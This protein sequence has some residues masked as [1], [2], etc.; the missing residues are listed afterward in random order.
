MVSVN[1]KAALL[2][3]PL[4]RLEDRTPFMASKKEL[5]VR[6]HGPVSPVRKYGGEGGI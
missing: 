3:L 2:G 6:R 4:E 1:D 5:V